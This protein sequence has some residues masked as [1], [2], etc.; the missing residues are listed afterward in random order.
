V[1]GKVVGWNV[2]GASVVDGASGGGINEGGANTT[3]VDDIPV[4][5]AFGEAVVV[6]RAE[7]PMGRRGAEGFDFWALLRRTGANARAADHPSRLRD[8]NLY[9]NQEFII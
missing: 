9:F 5:G 8:A 6:G 3:A 2:G 1:V 4:V 7:A